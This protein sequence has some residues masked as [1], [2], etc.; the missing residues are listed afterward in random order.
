M[1]PSYISLYRSPGRDSTLQL[2]WCVWSSRS[3]ERRLTATAI[4]ASIAIYGASGPDPAKYTVKIDPQ[5]PQPFSQSFTTP[6]AT[7]NGR[8][9]LYSSDQLAYA[10]HQIQIINEGSGLLL[11][12]IEIG[13]ELSAQ[14]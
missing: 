13:T 11:D 3:A 5:L 1:T 10:P 2:Y 6:N 8:T 4:G 9:L 14:G 7:G 12:V